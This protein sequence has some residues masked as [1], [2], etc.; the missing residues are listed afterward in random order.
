MQSLRRL[1][2]TV[3]VVLLLLSCAFAID[4]KDGIA[5]VF[6]AKTEKLIGSDAYRKGIEALEATLYDAYVQYDIITSDEVLEGALDY[7]EAVILL[8]QSAMSDQEV[9]LY[10][11]YVNSGGHIIASYTTSLYDAK[12]NL[13]ED[14]ALGDVLNVTLSSIMPLKPLLGAVPIDPEPPFAADTMMVPSSQTLMVKEIGGV[15][16]YI[17]LT[18]PDGEFTHYITNTIK[19]DSTVYF[20]ENIF[21]TETSD[22]YGEVLVRLLEEFLGDIEGGFFRLSVRDIQDPLNEGKS[23]YKTIEREFKVAERNYE[24]IPE[25]SLKAYEDAQKVYTALRFAERKDSGEKAGSYL[26]QLNQLTS[27]MIP[28]I[29]QTRNAEARAVWI[30]YQSFEACKSEEDFREIIRKLARANINMIFPE[31]VYSGATLYKSAVGE[32]HAVFRDFPF[33]PLEVVIDEAKKFGIE[34]HPWVWVFCGGYWGKFGPALETHPEWRELDEAGRPFSNWEYQTAWY[35]AAHPEVRAY[36]LDLFREVVTKY[37]VDGL[38]I[39]YIRYNEDGI[40]HFGYSDYSKEAFFQ[41]TGLRLDEIRVG[42][43]EWIAFNTWR[44]NN[45]TT[46][47]EEVRKML[48]ST[49]PDL[50]LSAAVVPD[51]DRSRADV[52][53]NWKHWVDNGYL[54]FVMT[55]D[56][57]N[58]V[59]GFKAN[60]NKG[61]AIVEDKAWVYPGLGLYVNDRI[62]N[63]GQIKATREVGSTGVALFSN[64]S[65]WKEK[66]DDAVN[67][68][69]ANPAVIPMREP[70]KAALILLD[71]ASAKLSRASLE[72]VAK[73]VTALEAEIAVSEVSLDTAKAFAEKTKALLDVLETLRAERIIKPSEIESLSSALVSAN[74]IFNIYVYQNTERDY[75]PATPRTN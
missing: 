51:P 41:A 11:D 22:K 20:A 38:H 52:M 40:G 15:E 73:E 42:S 60:A 24:E 53:Q 9:E 1:I 29:L 57:R 44:E 61:L 6:D 33:D 27:Q 69:F 34:V 62:T 5:I 75:V 2:S 39:D 67:G 64:A 16:D 14:F 50:L 10:R 66:Y 31:T 56:Y 74:R 28:G 47:V 70:F 59:P 71:E 32:Q 12:G 54:D 35:N 46:F 45:V 8:A 18:R 72:E 25:E 13:R 17:L 63:I 26:Y 55:M 23:W 37:D 36:L 68:L 43:K 58:E 48:N 3:I 49:N 30:D 65:F 7:Y 21:M 19:T 4:L